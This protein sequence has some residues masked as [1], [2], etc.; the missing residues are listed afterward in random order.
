VRNYITREKALARARELHGDDVQSVMHYGG[1]P[2]KENPR[3]WRCLIVRVHE[4]L[5]ASWPVMEVLGHGCRWKDAMRSAEASAKADRRYG[6]LLDMTKEDARQMTKNY[7]NL[8]AGRFG[9]D[10]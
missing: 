6:D 8:L 1:L 2:A 3:D 5:R 9:R 10:D 4:G 7:V